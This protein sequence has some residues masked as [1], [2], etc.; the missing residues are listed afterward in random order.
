MKKVV[1]SAV[2]V[3]FVVSLIGGA[4]THQPD[5]AV[6]LAGEDGQTS[7]TTSTKTQAKPASAQASDI[8]TV[9]KRLCDRL[10]L[11]QSKLREIEKSISEASAF[12]HQFKKASERVQQESLLPISDRKTVAKQTPQEKPTLVPAEK[13][14]GQVQVIRELKTVNQSVM[15]LR[16]HL[17]QEIVDMKRSWKEIESDLS[18]MKRA[19]GGPATLNPDRQCV[20]K[21]VKETQISLARLGTQAGNLK[22]QI[23]DV[24]SQFDQQYGHVSCAD[25]GSDCNSGECETC[26]A[27]QNKLTEPQGSL[28]RTIQ[29]QEL[30]LCLLACERAQAA[31]QFENFDQKVNSLFNIL[32]T[33]LKNEKEMQQ[34][35]V[36]NI[37]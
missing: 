15:R 11:F 16:A 10:K 18:H 5:Q 34:G 24:R 17:S 31:C 28:G 2:A 27:W 26:C 13:I 3:L 35:I 20:A 8:A 9:E 7:S 22:S 25:F 4:G 23:D 33:V 29:E 32:S 1:L 36:R 19:P 12:H 14:Q 6:I 21:E 30:K 37:Y